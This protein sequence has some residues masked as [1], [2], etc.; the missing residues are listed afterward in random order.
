MPDSQKILFSPFKNATRE[1]PLIAPFYLCGSC[2]SAY[3]YNT[4]GQ[5]SQQV[6][7][8]GFKLNLL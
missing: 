6:L 8:P 5:I 7:R 1:I 4:H 3:L 2:G